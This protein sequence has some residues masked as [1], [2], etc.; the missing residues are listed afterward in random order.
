MADEKD[1]TKVF[2]SL[3][4]LLGQTDLSD[5]TAESGGFS[6]LPDGYY[7]CEVESAELTESKSSHQ[8]MVAFQFKVV[9]D[10]MFIDEKTGEE[11]VLTKTKN[12][13]LFKYY[14]L[15]DEGGVKRFV[16]DMLK[17]EGNTAGEPV[18]P[19]EAFTTSATLLDALDALI[20]MCIYYRIN[21]TTDKD[22]HDSK[23][24][25]PISWKRAQALDLPM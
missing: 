13:K 17:F 23:W 7:L 25:S 24:Q 19:K 10:G 11:K 20:G 3:D 18:L 4:A 9:E 14:V 1:M 16:A 6:D 5:I 15:K 12:R 2:N 8:P 22:G 21:T